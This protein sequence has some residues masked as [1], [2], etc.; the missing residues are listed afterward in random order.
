M[1]K[2]DQETKGKMYKSPGSADLR[3]RIDLLERSNDDLKRA[4][5]D[6]EKRIVFIEENIPA[7]DG[8]GDVVGP[9]FE[10]EGL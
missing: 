4:I 10:N 2:K 8:R 3:R 9:F 5:R 7:S 6:L 1:T